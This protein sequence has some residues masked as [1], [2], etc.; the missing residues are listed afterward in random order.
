MRFSVLFFFLAF[1]SSFIYLESVVIDLDGMGW[2]G[3]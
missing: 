3:I 1:C 2:D